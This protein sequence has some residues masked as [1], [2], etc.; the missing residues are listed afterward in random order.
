VPGAK[1]QTAAFTFIFITVL[2]D[3]LAFG[4]IIPVLPKLIVDFMRGDTAVH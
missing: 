4:T 1:P 3:M 2:L